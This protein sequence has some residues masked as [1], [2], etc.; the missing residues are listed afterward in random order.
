ML[1][2]GVRDTGRPDA[3][4]ACVHGRGRV[5][6][7]HVRVRSRPRVR[8]LRRCRATLPHRRPRDRAPAR[9]HGPL[10]RARSRRAHCARFRSNELDKKFYVDDWTRQHYTYFRSIQLQ[11]S[12]M[13]VILSLVIAVAAFNIVS[14]LMMVVR[15]KRGDIAILRSFGTTPRSIVA[16][17]AS[18]GT[19][20]GVGRHVARRRARA[21]REL[22]ARQHRDAAA[23]AGSD[24]DLLS[25]DVYF[26]SD[27]PT[28]L[29][30]FEVAEIAVLALVLAVARDV[31]SVAQRRAPAAG[32]GVCVMNETAPAVLEAIGL[33]KTFADVGRKIEVLRG[34]EL[35][36]A[37]GDRVAIIGASGS[38]KTT[39]LQLLGGLDEPTSGRGARRGRIDEPRE[40]RRARPP[41]QSR[42]RLR[43]PVPSPA[44]RVHGAR[45][46]RDAAARAREP[47]RATRPRR[48]RRCSSAWASAS[49]S[50]IGP[51][52]CRAAS[53]SAR[54]SRARSSPGRP[55]CSR[56]SRPAISTGPRASRCSSCCS[57]S[58]RRSAR[59]SSS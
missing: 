22:A 36:V 57:S 26:L 8:E 49:G 16:I 51:A 2:E 25:A 13:F 12:I 54:R 28:Q 23:R 20:I 58:T 46:R 3:A 48:R 32:R 4:P 14:T 27:L 7:R 31:V 59:A 43:L 30:P 18:Q 47:R 39:L 5:R 52:S 53:G 11:K 19:L 56:T 17:F 24:I 34:V 29:R 45:E 9:G 37:K 15:D 42:A 38:G 44:A 50:S 21:A 55:R 6:G 33:V 10:Q 1:A 40:R 35:S 41:A